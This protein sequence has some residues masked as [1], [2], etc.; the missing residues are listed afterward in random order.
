MLK[1]IY[2]SGHVLPV[3]SRCYGL[4]CVQ[5]LIP[6]CTFLKFHTYLGLN[7]TRLLQNVFDKRSR[8]LNLVF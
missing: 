7:S 3:N 2:T 5:K 1:L 6:L 8:V 4:W